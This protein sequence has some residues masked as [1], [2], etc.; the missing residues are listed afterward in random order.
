MMGDTHVSMNYKVVDEDIKVMSGNQLVDANASVTV[1][2]SEVDL[3]ITTSL[4]QWAEYDSASPED[5]KVWDD[6]IASLTAHEDG[7]KAIAEKGAHALDKALAG[8]HAA[9]NGKTTTAAR[10]AAQQKVNQ[11]VKAKANQ[12]FDKTKKEQEQ[13]DKCT[14]HGANQNHPS[15]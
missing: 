6:S 11:Q 2:K 7:H 3:T 1:T 15:C 14:G 5:K 8:T 4:P 13:Y 10:Q 12:Q 9:A